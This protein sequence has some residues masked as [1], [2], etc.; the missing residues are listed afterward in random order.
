MDYQLPEE[1]RILR[2]NVRRFVDR[3]LIPVEQNSLDGAK[4][5]SKLQA[6]LEKK[7]QFSK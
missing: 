6:N 7:H 3:E 5:K 1:L 4:L 2:H